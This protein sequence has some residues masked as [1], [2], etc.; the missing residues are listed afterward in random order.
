MEEGGTNW[1]RAARIDLP[2]SGSKD[3]KSGTWQGQQ[4]LEKPR[5]GG[6]EH[7]SERH[8]KPQEGRGLK[9]SERGKDAQRGE[10][11]GGIGG[12]ITMSWS[13]DLTGGGGGG[14]GF[15]KSKHNGGRSG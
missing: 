3:L 14:G 12:H 13:W 5:K 9:N 8:G 4:N 11:V 7:V 1:G 6:G 10:T 2:P 15:K